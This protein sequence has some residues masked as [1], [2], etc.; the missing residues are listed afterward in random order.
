MMADLFHRF[1]RIVASILVTGSL[2]SAAIGD[3]PVEPAQTGPTPLHPV[4]ADL[5]R[6]LEVLSSNGIPVRADAP[7]G[8]LYECL[9]QTADPAAR[10]FSASVYEHHLQELAGRDFS[11]A[12]SIT[13]SNAVPR[14]ASLAADAP[15]GLQPGDRIVAIDGTPTTNSTIGD[16][17][18]LLRG[19]AAT[20]LSLVIARDDASTA[21][22]S[23]ARALARLP[24]I[25]LSET[26]PRELGYARFNGFF[27]DSATA[28]VALVRGW[29]DAG[30]AGGIL[31]LRGAGGDAIG[32]IAAFAGLFASR[33]S[34][35]FS[36]RDA[37]ENDLGSFKADGASRIELPLMVLVDE[38]THGAAEVFAA[39]AFDSL[40]G[41]L[42]VGRPTMGDPAIRSGLA[43]SDDLVLYIATRRLVTGN[44]SV[45]DGRARVTPHLVVQRAAR[46][47]FEPPP[48]P[49]RRMRLDEEDA[50]RALRDRVRG[51][52][53]LQRAVDV[54]LGLKALNIKPGAL[55]SP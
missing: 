41:L 13:M 6:L 40:K 8:P 50:D 22:V 35:L 26:W 18:A 32:D 7:R 44:G 49:D 43:L 48:G 16:A 51:D 21:T 9:S 34:V 12:F 14:V 28:A 39:A 36:F 20:N 24:A 11:P 54:L 38:T 17:I 42:L 30:F 27:A 45:L 15:A 23:V 4:V 5:S 10:I 37:E 31:D 47:D 29:A 46:V 1:L 3:E 55:S 25:E 19:H 53:V 2:C 52:A 33:G